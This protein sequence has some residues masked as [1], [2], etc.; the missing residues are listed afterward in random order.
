[1]EKNGVLTISSG[2]LLHNIRAN[3]ILIH[4]NQSFHIQTSRWP[5]SPPGHSRHRLF[6]RRARLVRHS[7]TRRSHQA[8]RANGV[9][10][11]ADKCHAPDA[12]EI[13]I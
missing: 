11:L 13:Q 5:H 10:Q 7:Y 2:R 6:H 3:K 4:K 12:R 1:M 8:K 9:G